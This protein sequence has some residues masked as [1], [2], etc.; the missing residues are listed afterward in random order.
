[1]IQMIWNI[2]VN[3]MLLLVILIKNHDSNHQEQSHESDDNGKDTDSNH[4]SDDQKQSSKSDD[5]DNDSDSNH[6]SDYQKQSSKSDDYDNDSDSIHDSDYQEQSSKSND[7][8][9]DSDSNDDSDFHER[10]SELDHANNSEITYSSAGQAY[11]DD[12]SDQYYPYTTDASDKSW[13]SDYLISLQNHGPVLGGYG[14][15]IRNVKPNKVTEQSKL[16]KGFDFD[17]ATNTYVTPMKAIEFNPYLK[18]K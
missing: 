15:K 18:S 9:N 6:D 11:D 16:G 4:D 1:M 5:Y 13:E 12:F 7:Y 14:R 8:D 17:F 10:S 2:T 3:Q